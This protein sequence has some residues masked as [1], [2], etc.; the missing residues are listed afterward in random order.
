MD[1]ALFAKMLSDKSILDL[2]KL[3]YKYPQADLKEFVA[4]LGN[5]FYKPL[6]LNDFDGAN[7]VYLESVAQVACQQ[8]GCC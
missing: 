5:G 8:P 4:L 6:T 1:A 2:K 7:L 3:C